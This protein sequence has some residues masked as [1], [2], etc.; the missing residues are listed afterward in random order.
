MQDE[1]QPEHIPVSMGWR[2]PDDSRVKVTYNTRVIAYE[3]ARDR[4]LVV[5]ENLQDPSGFDSR[6]SLPGDARAKILALS[7]KWAYVPDEA[8]NGV[9]LPLKYETLT[10]Q[11]RFFYTGDPRLQSNK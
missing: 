10:G 11:I 5:L 6:T 4:W 9:T 7:G 8:R 2:L 3:A 1:Q